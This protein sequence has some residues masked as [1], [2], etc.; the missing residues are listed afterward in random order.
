MTGSFYRSVSGAFFA[1]WLL[2]ACAST[3]GLTPAD[4]AQLE[5]TN[6][7][8]IEQSV[9]TGGQ[10]TERDL[11]RLRD[12]GVTTIVTLRGSNEDTGFDERA[13]VETL[14]M[15]YISLPVSMSEGLDVETARKL[16]DILDKSD[17]PALVH[18]GSGNRVGA[19]YAIGAHEIDGVPL[20]QAL[21]IGRAAGLTRLEP[22]IR[23]MLEGPDLD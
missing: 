22:R 11:E 12:S 18:C 21:E 6:P 3:S 1:G 5:L 9:I 23:E 2:S 4:T 15:S 17:G 7:Q 10:P 8:I 16:R 13:K 14:G 19:I 20:E